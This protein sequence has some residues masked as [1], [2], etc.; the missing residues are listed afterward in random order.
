MSSLKAL[1]IV[2]ALVFATTQ[3][4]SGA[5]ARGLRLGLGIGLPV[6]AAIFAAGIHERQQAEAMRRRA[7]IAQEAR[8][9]ERARQAQ[10]AKVRAAAKAAAQ[11]EANKVEIARKS[12][13]SRIAEAA[14][15]SAPLIHPAKTVVTA[16]AP[17]PVTTAPSAEQD[18]VPSN[19][20]ILPVQKTAD[21]LC[22]RFLPTAGV[23]IAVPCG[24]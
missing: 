18:V 10:A 20:P 19:G 9:V 24:E 5:E 23:T 11:A 22:Q 16:R 13:V 1:T 17:T 7:A 8:T 4:T 6:A 15:Q 14:R 3:A 12:K 2:A 21:E